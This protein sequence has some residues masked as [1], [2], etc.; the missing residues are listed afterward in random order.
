MVKR[1]QQHFGKA[2]AIAAVLGATLAVSAPATAGPDHSVAR[3]WNDAMLD[4]IRKDFARPT[5]HARNLYHVSAAM[6]DTW[7]A[8]QTDADQVLFMEKVDTAK[9]KDIEA[10]REESISHA[11]YNVLRSRFGKS[12]GAKETLPALD[13]L[14]DALGYDK[15]NQATVGNSPAAV[16]NRCAVTILA[17]GLNDGSNEQG[18]YD[19]LFYEPVNPPLLPDFYGNPDLEDEWRWQPL[20]LEY[21]V[22]QGGNVII[23]G[24]PGALSPEWGV[25]T[26]FSL[27]ANNLDIYHRDGFDYWV[28]YDPGPPPLIG[29]GE[30]GDEYYKWGSAQVAIWS[31]HLDPADGVMI[32]ISPGAIG[33]SPTPQA[34]E[35]DEYYDLLE[36]GDWGTGHDVNPYTG[37]PYE[38]NIVPRGDYGRVLAEFWADGPDS[39]TPPGHWFTLLNYVSDHPLFEKRFAGEGDILDDLQWDVKSYLIM[40][41]AMHDVA[42][43][44][45]GIKGWYDYIR[46]VSA[47]RWQSDQGQSSDPRGPSY[48]PNGMTLYPGLIEVITEETAK[49]YHADPCA[50]CAADPDCVDCIGKIAIRAWRGPDEL[51]QNDPAGV[52]WILAGKWWPYQRPTFVTPPFPGYVSGHSTYSRGAA[53]VMTFMTGDEFWPGGMATFYCPMNAF[54]VFEQGPSQDIT[55]QWA[56]YQDASDQTSLSRIWGGIHPGADDLPGRL[57]GEEIGPHAFCYSVRIFNGQLSCPGDTNNDGMV[58]TTDLVNLL[59]AWGSQECTADLDGDDVVGAG[60][61]ILLLG[62]W[63]PCS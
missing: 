29:E 58:D 60:D 23:G 11:A 43:A 25:V 13:A 31:S 51:K 2:A 37:R 19:N 34:D 41:G 1:R 14:M 18:G 54:L 20:A 46:P 9:I 47:I 33:N 38:P 16:G 24:Y 59:G 28:Y 62:D 12:P 27:T 63:G 6:W 39:E 40:G 53:H 42:I 48:D 8:Y 32:D 30:P 52:G 4:A 35:W 10:A 26:P 22:D 15:D 55:L 5:V 61:L 3:Q 49:T 7:A 57:I 44:A 45:W 56:T 21:F 36:G 50:V 17:F